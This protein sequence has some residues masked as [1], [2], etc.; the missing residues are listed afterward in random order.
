M[1]LYYSPGACSLA[2]HIALVESGE[3]YEKTKVDLAS[4][5]TENGEDFRT[6]SPRGY[7]PA[8]QTDDMGL[9]TENPA[10]LTYI[11]NATTKLENHADHYKRLEW[12]GFVGTE[13]HGAFGPLFGGAEGEAKEKAKAKVADKFSM[14]ETLMDGREWLVGDNPTVAD[15]YL[16]VTTLWAD[17]FGIDLPQSLQ[18]FRARNLERPAVKQAMDEEGL[19]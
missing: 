19:S 8:I 10:V 5:E 2:S 7:V 15:N 11:A 4:H 13:I 3:P 16:F 14:A 1:K 6:I 17:K 9:L 12:L 18:D